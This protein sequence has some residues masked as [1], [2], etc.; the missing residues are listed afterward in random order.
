[1][2]FFNFKAAKFII[3]FFTITGLFTNCRLFD[4]KADV[5]TIS[6]S[7]PNW[8]P[9][10]DYPPLSRWKITL[11]KSD[12]RLI[13]YANTDEILKITLQKNCPFSLQAH[14]ITLLQDGIECS[15]FYPAGFVYPVSGKNQACWEEG[16]TAFIMDGL[17]KNCKNNGFSNSQAA[18]YVST[19]N[20]K[21]MN[22]SIC[23][24]ISASINNETKFYNPWLCDSAKIIENLSNESFRTSLLSPAATYQLSTE[25]IIQEKPRIFS[26]FIP[27]N[28]ILQKS[29]QIT[30]KKDSPMLLSDLKEFGLFITYLSAKNVQIEYIYIPI[31][32]EEI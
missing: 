10:P 15:Y 22:S 29:G 25:S 21:K 11:S 24:K 26:P 8:P 27:E 28:P 1:M 32:K 17:Y 16:F 3:I 30:I 31:Y 12:E 23:E 20:W 14:P 5:E 6:L 9:S 18:R 19:F 13:F 7:L 4:E 2:S